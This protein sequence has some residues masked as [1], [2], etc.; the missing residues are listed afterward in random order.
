MNIKIHPDT[1]NYTCALDDAIGGV[2]NIF[3][4]GIKLISGSKK[5]EDKKWVKKVD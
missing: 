2:G 5:K 4:S 1:G 3:K